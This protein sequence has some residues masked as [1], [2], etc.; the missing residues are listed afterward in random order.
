MPDYN[1]FKNSFEKRN[2]IGTFICYY[3]LLILLQEITFDAYGKV[4]CYWNFVGGFKCCCWNL[5][6]RMEKHYKILVVFNV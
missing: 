3:R 2:D 5:V 4:S 1:F 6:G